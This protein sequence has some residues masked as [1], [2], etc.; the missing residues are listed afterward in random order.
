[1][2][3][4]AVQKWVQFGEVADLLVNATRFAAS[5]DGLA[6]R[7]GEEM[8]VRFGFSHCEGYS[9]KFPERPGYDTPTSGV[10]GADPGFGKRSPYV[11]AVLAPDPKTGEVPETGL[12]RLL[13]DASRFFG[14]SAPD[15]ALARY[16]R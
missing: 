2:E 13:R 7:T 3:G 10:F 8:E 16:A 4:G 14:A 6:G 12:L 5:C 9:L 11:S 15:K 1:M